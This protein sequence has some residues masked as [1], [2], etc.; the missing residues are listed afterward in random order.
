MELA[1]NYHKRL[2]TFLAPPSYLIWDLTVIASQGEYSNTLTQ[3]ALTPVTSHASLP[4]RIKR[5]NV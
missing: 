2:A 5:Y 1:T 4:H 3:Q